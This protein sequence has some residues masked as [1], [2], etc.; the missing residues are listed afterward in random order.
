VA[1]F[2]STRHTFISGIVA[3]GASVKVCQELAR[4][5]TPTLTI[6][7]YSHTRLHDVAAALDSLPNLD[8]TKPETESATMVATGT[9]GKTT[10]GDV[11]CHQNR[12]LLGGELGRNT[13]NDGD[14]WRNRQHDDDSPKLLP[15]SELAIKKPPVARKAPVGVEPTMADLQCT[16]RFRTGFRYRLNIE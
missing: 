6:G 4:H 13:A 1:D 14:G 10:F 3:G 15:C 2:H 8:A 16:D 9:D 12:T 7:R 5:S 11:R